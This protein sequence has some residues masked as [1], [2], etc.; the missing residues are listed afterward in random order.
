MFMKIRSNS[1]HLTMEFFTEEELKE[2]CEKMLLLSRG[3]N[4]IIYDINLR[5]E[6]IS[7]YGEEGELVIIIPEE[8][9][10]DS[11]SVDL[12]KEKL[13]L[14]ELREDSSKFIKYTTIKEEEDS[15]D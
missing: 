6:L 12:G 13:E 1:K 3:I 9:S 15:Y 10:V 2:K 8:V 11:Y 7:K 14:V 5:N 4:E